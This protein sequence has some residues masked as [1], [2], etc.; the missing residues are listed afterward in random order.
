MKVEL[1]ERDSKAPDS[2]LQAPE[3]FQNQNINHHFRDFLLELGD[4]EFLWC[5]DVGF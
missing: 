3:N 4:L 5:L 1:S 2:K